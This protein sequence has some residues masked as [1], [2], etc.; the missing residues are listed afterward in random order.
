MMMASE[1]GGKANIWH[2]LNMGR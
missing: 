2:R 1:D